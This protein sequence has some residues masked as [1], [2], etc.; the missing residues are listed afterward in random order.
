ML[1]DAAPIAV[2]AT[3]DLADRLDGFGRVVDVDHL[4]DYGPP[5]RALPAPEPG[6]VAYPMY[7]SGTTGTPKGVA[8]THQNVVMLLQSL[9]A[10]L[11]PGGVGTQFHSLAFD[12]SVWEIFGALIGGGR[13]VVVPDEVARSPDE[14]HALLVDER[15][16]VLS[17]SRRRSTR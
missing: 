12:F 10:M 1:A 14:F 4:G 5:G 11:P 15:V 16:T 9:T 8:I 6:D 17:Q 7:T 13:L 3:T 2:L